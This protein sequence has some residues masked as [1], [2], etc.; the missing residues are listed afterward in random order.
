MSNSP[1]DI[2]FSS[3]ESIVECIGFFFLSNIWFCHLQTSHHSWTFNPASISWSQFKLLWLLISILLSSLYPSISPQRRI[4][5]IQHHSKDLSQ[6]CR[7]SDSLKW[8]SLEHVLE[9]FSFKVYT[10]C[11]PACNRFYCSISFSPFEVGHDEGV[12][13][14]I[15]WVKLCS[16]VMHTHNILCNFFSD[17]VKCNPAHLYFLTKWGLKILARTD[18]LSPKINAGNSHLF[19]LAFYW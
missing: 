5:R 1:S 2:H 12:Y 8:D 15:I 16:L 9:I 19:C 11:I 14:H 17:I 6:I 18:W 4:Q 13:T 3:A 7:V 10:Q